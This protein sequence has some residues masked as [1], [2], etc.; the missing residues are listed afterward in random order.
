M[1]ISPID[2]EIIG[3]QEII[4]KKKEFNVSRTYSMWCTHAAHAKNGD[5][6]F[7]LPSNAKNT[8][9]MVAKISTQFLR[10]S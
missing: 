1:K 7:S 9:T 2:P 3:L 8:L 5:I 10:E 6:I 4:F